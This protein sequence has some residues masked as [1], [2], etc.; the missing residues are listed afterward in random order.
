MNNNNKC[1]TTVNGN[2]ESKIQRFLRLLLKP[3]YEQFPFVLLF[4]CTIDFWSVY[5]LAIDC[6][7]STEKISSILSFGD[8]SVNAAILF[9]FAYVAAW[10][11]S[12]IRNA[13]LRR[14]AKTFMYGLLLFL[15]LLR[16]FLRHNFNLDI[17]INFFILL[18][19][20]SKTEIV[21]FV[22]HY[23]F[24]INT[25]FML[26]VL[27]VYAVVILALEYF[28]DSKKNYIK[29]IPLRVKNVVS[30]IILLL[31]LSGVYSTKV[32]CKLYSAHS[33]EEM[34]MF[35][36]PNDPISSTYV[37]LLKL[38]IMND[39][40]RSAIELN[41]GVYENEDVHTVKDDTVNV[42][43]VIGESYIKWHSQLYGYG[44]E[45]TP[46][47]YREM[48][49]GRLFVFND[50]ISSSNSTSEVMRNLLCC[51]NSSEKEMW[52]DY[53][54]FL[55]IFKK[56]GYNVYFWDNQC[57]SSI[58]SNY[59]Y[60]LNSFLYSPELSKVFYSQTNSESF[61]YDADLVESLNEAFDASSEQKNLV[62]FHLSGQHVAP[63][64]R[65]PH[66]TFKHFTAENIKRNDA[67][68]TENMK[69]YIADYDNAT[70]YNDYVMSKIFD[71][72]KDSNTILVYFS[73]HGEEAYDFREHS[74]RD[75]GEL[76]PM[77]LKYQYDVPFVVWCSETYKKNNS[78]V[79][80]SISKAV[81]RPFMLDNVCNMLFNLGGIS[82]SY[83]RE[84]LDL[85]SPNYYCRERYLL[86][87]KYVY[88]DIRYAY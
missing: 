22:N 63:S 48:C 38:R 62:V 83:Y 6:I 17:N 9:L 75:H 64:K 36:F 32:Y 42:V 50:V 14:L 2:G 59:S 68:L 41:K 60:V 77:V 28:W 51:N 80:E 19:G 43:V 44:L 7:T 35:D 78:D 79:V 16:Y 18:A 71:K 66:D 37:S 33:Y 47:M 52:F 54:S 34:I 21:E 13:P 76:T 55:T 10:V 39:N 40:V 23:F 3:I 49:D 73:D 1:A 57:E 74:G 53:P 25:L 67:Y 61:E 88:E 5:N 70:L 65:F 46:N 85:I 29:K 84:N 20:A 69:E 8:L 72:F 82:T 11:I 81:N 58:L 86:R 31:L 30:V 27:M 15:F 26:L 87:G 12:V 56:A 24:S 4:L 45:T